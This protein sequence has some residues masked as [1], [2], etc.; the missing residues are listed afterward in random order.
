[1]QFERPMIV[2]K[3]FQD[4]MYKMIEG[5]VLKSVLQ[6]IEIERVVLQVV[7]RNF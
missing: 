6:K 1:M 2:M 7:E 3:R 4:Q 5:Q